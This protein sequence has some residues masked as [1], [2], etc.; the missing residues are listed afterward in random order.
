MPT[1]DEHLKEIESWVEEIVADRGGTI[2]ADECYSDVVHAYLSA[3]VGDAQTRR[4]ILRR[5]GL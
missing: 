1:V 3:E 4:E 2:T 5:T